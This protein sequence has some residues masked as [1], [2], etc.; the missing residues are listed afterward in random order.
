MK[1]VVSALIGLS[2]AFF[3]PF[4][5]AFFLLEVSNPDEYMSRD[6]IVALALSTAFSSTFSVAG[7]VIG[8]GFFV[9]RSKKGGKP[10]EQ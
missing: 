8:E 6:D 1:S 7:F 10:D 2:M 3:A 9:K 5:I 4:S